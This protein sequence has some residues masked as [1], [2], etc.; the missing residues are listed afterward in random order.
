MENNRMD[1][2]QSYVNTEEINDKQAQ[3]YARDIVLYGWGGGFRD[4]T[5]FQ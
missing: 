3:R 5:L 4:E 2:I 1:A